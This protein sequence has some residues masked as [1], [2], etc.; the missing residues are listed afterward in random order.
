MCF[1]FLQNKGVSFEYTG[2]IL[3]AHACIFEEQKSILKHNSEFFYKYTLVFSKIHLSIL[4][5]YETKTWNIFAFLYFKIHF[6]YFQNTLLYFKIH[7]CILEK[8]IPLFYAFLKNIGVCFEIHTFI[9]K[10]QSCILHFAICALF[11]ATMSTFL[12]Q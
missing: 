10:I 6:L 7:G 12:A 4:K 5:K 9:W 2:C 1:V 3:K 11:A 8:I